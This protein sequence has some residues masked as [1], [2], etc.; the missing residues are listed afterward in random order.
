MIDVNGVILILGFFTIIG[1]AVGVL[2][3][4]RHRHAIDGSQTKVRNAGAENRHKSG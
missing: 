4:I 1:V 2:F 3:W